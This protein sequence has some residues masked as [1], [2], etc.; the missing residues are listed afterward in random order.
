MGI[1]VLVKRDMKVQQKRICDMSNFKHNLDNSLT[2]YDLYSIND[3]IGDVLDSNGSSLKILKK[4]G[5]CYIYGVITPTG[6]I[7]DATTV[8]NGLPK[9]LFGNTTWIISLPSITYVRPLLFQVMSDGSVNVRWGSN[10]K[11]SINV[12]YPYKE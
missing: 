11:H 10:S 2:S 9:P 3:F 4:N 12:I 5:W 8:V 7:A 6:N 1:I